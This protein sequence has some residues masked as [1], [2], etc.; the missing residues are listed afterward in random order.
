MCFKDDKRISKGLGHTIDFQVKGSNFE[1]KTYSPH[2][3][4]WKSASRL[5]SIQEESEKIVSQYNRVVEGTQKGKDGY[6]PAEW[7][8]RLKFARHDARRFQDW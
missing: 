2:A 3:L 1:L 4:Q 8:F 6:I 5:K 7:H